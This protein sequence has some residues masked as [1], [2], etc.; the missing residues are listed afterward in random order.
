V[1]FSDPH[2]GFQGAP[3]PLGTKAFEATVELINQS[4]Q[5]PGFVLFTGD[6]TH[7][8]DSRDARAQRMHLIK[9]IASH[10]ETSPIHTV[11][12]KNDAALDGGVPLQRAFRGE[13]FGE[14]HYSF[15]HKGVHFVALDN[16]SRGR[17]EV[18]PDQFAWLK[19]DIAR[20]PNTS[21][22]VVFTHRPLFDLKPE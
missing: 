14:S 2:V 7:D 6:L 1:Q 17:P 15:D 9:S 4:R 21:S 19:A 10:I 5:R 12:G 13:H 11:P 8:A 18:G 16:V 22:I 20:F 3:D